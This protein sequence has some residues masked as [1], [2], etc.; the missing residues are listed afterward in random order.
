MI[1][2]LPFPAS[3]DFM[4]KLYGSARLCAVLLV[5]SVRFARDEIALYGEEEPSEKLSR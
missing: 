1:R 5:H 3:E 2:Y 4:R